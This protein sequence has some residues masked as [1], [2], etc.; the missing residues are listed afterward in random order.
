ML[1]ELI[2]NKYIEARG[3]IGFYPA[4][5]VNDDDIEVYEDREKTRKLCTF[6]TLRQQIDRDQ[7]NF[8][9]LS[10]FIAPQSSGKT[11]YIGFFAVSAG[12]KQEEICKK[13]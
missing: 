4:N 7:N 9:A 11:D 8:V 6:F 5:T 2:E 13:Y 3:I 10:D 1:K 12:F